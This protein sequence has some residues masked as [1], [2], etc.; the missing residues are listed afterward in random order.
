MEN[1]FSQRLPPGGCA[2]FMPPGLVPANFIAMRMG[3]Q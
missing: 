3:V 1:L 2:A